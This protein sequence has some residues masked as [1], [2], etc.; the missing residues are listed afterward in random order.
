MV[1]KILSLGNPK[2]YETSDTIKTEEIEKIREVVCDL[3]DTIVD[4][5]EKYHTGRAIAAPQIG[6][7][8]RLIYMYIDAPIILI[9]PKLEFIG[10]E[11]M[12]LFDDCMSFPGLYVKVRRHRKCKIYYKDMNWHDCEM[13]LTGE[14]S[15]LLQHECDHLDGILATMRAIDS[16]SYYFKENLTDME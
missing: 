2:L 5:Q 10:T 7:L 8:K 13:E 14:L 3:H 1:R 12:I 6:V 4:Y 9:N 16:K 11:E 15:E